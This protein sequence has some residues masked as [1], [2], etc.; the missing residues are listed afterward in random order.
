MPDSVR[1][2]KPA[3][4]SAPPLSRRFTRR[5]RHHLVLAGVNLLLILLIAD[6]FTAPP[7][8]R[9]SAASAYA[10]LLMLAVTLLLGPLNILLRRPNPVSTDLRRDCGIWAATL[11]ILHTGLALWMP[12]RG[13]FWRAFAIAPGRSWLDSLG[14][15]NDVGLVATVLLVLLATLSNDRSLRWLG[16]AWWKAVQ[17]LSYLLF[18]FVVAHTVLYDRLVQ[19]GS[20]Y[21]ALLVLVIA[22]VFTLQINGWLERRSR[23]AG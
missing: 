16:R 9:V 14:F 5:I 11:G 19:P 4:Q 18:V 17:R 12:L 23:R 22:L 21:Q 2:L 6:S 20:F 10:G 3:G 13:A 15:A 8:T 7:L 1:S